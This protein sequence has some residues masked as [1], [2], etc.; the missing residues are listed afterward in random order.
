MHKIL[1]VPSKSV[2]PESCVSSG[3][4][5]EGLMVTSSNRAYAIPRSAA[6]R[7]PDPVAGHCLPVPLQETLKHLKADLAQS[8][9]CTPGFV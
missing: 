2:F 1:F 7:A 6:P 5:I 9:W 3:G 8:L 4:S